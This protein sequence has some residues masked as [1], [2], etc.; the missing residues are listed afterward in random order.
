MKRC[1]RRVALAQ[2]GLAGAILGLCAVP[3]MAQEWPTKPVRMLVGSAPGGGTDAAARAVADKLGPALK[4]TVVVENKPGASNTL[5]PAEAVRAN[6][7]HSL[8]MG[9]STA[10]AIAPYLIKLPYNNDRDLVPVAYVG[11]VPNVLVVN[12][13]LGLNTVS[14]LVALV[15]KQPGKVNFASSGAGSTQHIAG[16]LFREAAQAD[17]T[18]VPYRGSAPA[19]VDLMGGSV[20]MS[21]DTM[22]SVLPHIK[23]GKVKALAVASAKRS[24]Q[25]PDVPTT[26]EAGLKNVEMS[27]WYG[28]YMPAGTPKAV[29]DKVHDEVTKIIQM[30]DV[31][32]RLEAI[33]MEV[34][35]MSQA[36]FQAFHN[37]ENKRYAALIKRRDIR[38]D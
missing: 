29:Q 36:Q 10:H 13:D 19:L 35:P 1:T 33:G 14:D 34:Q 15:R 5:A 16:E 22:A 9:V 26:A 6:D 18:H 24:P 27:A 3:A 32:A 17:I 2:A 25:L 20:Q 38:L 8:V 4:T 31:K 30:P 11:A 12:K 7:G 28:V 21:F 23:S 37:E